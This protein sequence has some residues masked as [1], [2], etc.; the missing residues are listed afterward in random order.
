MPHQ[1]RTIRDRAQSGKLLAL[2]P[3]ALVFA[4]ITFLALGANMKASEPTVATVAQASTNGDA[5]AQAAEEAAAA[6]VVRISLARVAPALPEEA[7]EPPKTTPR[8]AAPETQRKT[9]AP[10]RDASAQTSGQRAAAPPQIANAPAQ[11]A[12]TSER[13]VESAAETK[14]EGGI[15]TRLGSYAPSPRKIASSVSDS[16][17][18]LA[19]YIPGL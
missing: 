13:G 6:A 5:D 12:N 18:K 11:S 8:P 19:S 17:S 1:S 14:S 16:V 2:F 3:L 9:V 10:R 4:A 7:L 15:F